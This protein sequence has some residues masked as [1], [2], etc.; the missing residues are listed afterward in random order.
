M[1]RRAG[2]YG[3]LEDTESWRIRRAGG[4]GEL[5]DDFHRGMRSVLLGL[6]E[7]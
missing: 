6:T 1:I 3:E 2:G 5:E 7:H 4:Y